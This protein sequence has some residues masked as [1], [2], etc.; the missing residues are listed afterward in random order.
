MVREKIINGVD[1]SAGVPVTS[2]SAR[3]APITSLDD[4]ATVATSLPGSGVSPIGRRRTVSPRPAP[5]HAAH[6]SL[7]QSLWDMPGPGP[8]GPIS[9]GER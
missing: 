5:R 6:G 9:G 8:D 7:G 1:P 2:P 3:P 4:I